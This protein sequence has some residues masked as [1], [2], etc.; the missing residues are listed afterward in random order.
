MAALE[1]VGEYSRSFARRGLI[2]GSA[3]GRFPFCGAGTHKLG[4]LQHWIRNL[5]LAVHRT[6]VCFA[7]ETSRFNFLSGWFANWTC[8]HCIPLALCTAKQ[9]R[10]QQ[11]I[12]VS[13]TEQRA[14]SIAAGQSKKSPDGRPG[15]SLRVQ[16]RVIG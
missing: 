7:V 5:E 4:R 12:I 1:M 15:L 14:A 3:E 2:L 16:M 10:H 11:L 13:I 8:R 6:A 9:E